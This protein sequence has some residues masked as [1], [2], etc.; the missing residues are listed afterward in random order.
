MKSAYLCAHCGKV[1]MDSL[2]PWKQEEMTCQK[3]HK[4]LLTDGSITLHMTISPKDALTLQRTR[5][6]GLRQEMRREL[7]TRREK[8]QS[9]PSPIREVSIA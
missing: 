8:M 2:D 7:N 1:S 4:A 9:S 5:S 3:C 6:K